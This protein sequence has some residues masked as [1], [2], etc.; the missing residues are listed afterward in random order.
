VCERER[1]REEGDRQRERDRDRDRETER[2]RMYDREYRSCFT[3]KK[4]KKLKKIKFL[5]CKIW[6]KTNQAIEQARSSR[7]GYKFAIIPS[8]WKV[9]RR[10]NHWPSN[11]TYRS[12]N[13]SIPHD[14]RESADCQLQQSIYATSSEAPEERALPRLKG[15]SLCGCC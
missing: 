6:G 5:P 7:P 12:P 10:V 4:K 2:Q 14:T 3:K 9:V 1:E 15:N 11:T 13:F 8:L